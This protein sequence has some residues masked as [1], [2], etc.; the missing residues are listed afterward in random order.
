MID[1]N[2]GM[3]E[4]EIK[5]EYWKDEVVNCPHGCRKQRSKKS[6]SKNLLQRITRYL[7]LLCSNQQTTTKTGK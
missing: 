6:N 2:G 1:Y 5:G 4:Y 7:K 3:I